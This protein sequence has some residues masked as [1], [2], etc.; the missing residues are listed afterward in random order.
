M[1]KLYIFIT[2]ILLCTNT[3]SAQIPKKQIELQPYFRWDSY[4]TFTSTISNFAT[5][6]I[7]IKGKSGGINAA[8]KS[9]IRNN[10]FLKIGIGYY[11]F[12]FS[13]IER[14]HRVFGKSNVR[15]VSYTAPI[16]DINIYTPKYW[17][18]TF[19]ANIGIEKYFPLRSNYYVISGLTARNY[20]TF[21]QQYNMTLSTVENQKRYVKRQFGFSADLSAGIL[22]QMGKLGIGASVILPV[23]D[24]WRQDNFFPAEE[25]ASSRNKWFRGIGAGINCNYSLSKIKHH[26]K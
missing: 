3:L 9:E 24:K 18:N 4:P 23:Y 26:E 20:Y 12:S 17:Y 22:K 19:N 14:I 2:F 6:Q 25:N 21:S 8:Y 15:L 5:H 1:S 7:S 16:G 13:E 10:L 11:K